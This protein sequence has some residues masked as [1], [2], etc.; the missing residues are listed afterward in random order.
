[1][2][3]QTQIE[4]GTPILHTRV[5]EHRK[6]DGLEY[7][8]HVSMSMNGWSGYYVRPEGMIPWG[9]ARLTP[10]SDELVLPEDG[11]TQDEAIVEAIRDELL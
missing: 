7:G 6:V 4:D 5:P 3:V 2:G 1:M 9:I 11:E 10:A 8:A